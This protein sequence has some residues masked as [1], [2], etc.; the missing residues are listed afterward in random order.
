MDKKDIKMI[1][2]IIIAAVL[3][4]DAISF[5]AWVVSGQTPVDSFYFG[6]ITSNIIKLL[7]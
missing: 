1:I 6:A 5:M 3:I 4:V 2:L 7:I